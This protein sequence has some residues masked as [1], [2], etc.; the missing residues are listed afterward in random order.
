MEKE[1]PNIREINKYSMGSSLG[2]TWR[3]LRTFWFYLDS[4]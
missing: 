4:V 3:D 2:G 1:N